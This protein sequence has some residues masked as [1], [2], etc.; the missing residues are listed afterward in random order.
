MTITKQDLDNWIERE[1]ENI[2]S[3]HACNWGDCSHTRQVH[4]NKALVV[5]MAKEKLAPLLLQAV[6]ALKLYANPKNF[7]SGRINADD[8]YSAMKIV[9]RVIDVN[10]PRIEDIWVGGKKAFETLSQIEATINNTGKGA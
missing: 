2:L 3:Y 9:G 6:E 8:M 10:P 7:E 4:C 5:E 1:G